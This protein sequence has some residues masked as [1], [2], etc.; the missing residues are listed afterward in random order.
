MRGSKKGKRDT[1][2]KQR[3]FKKHW[4]SALIY[5]ASTLLI[6]IRRGVQV[7]NTLL[8]ATAKALG[9]S[10][11]QYRIALLIAALL[12]LLIGWSIFLM[13]IFHTATVTI[14]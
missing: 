6:Q 8:Y 5:S 7:L 10:H 11:M 9:Q 4:W 14:T 13:A 3:L 12:A 2:M 1:T